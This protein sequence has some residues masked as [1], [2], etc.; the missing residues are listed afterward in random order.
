MGQICGA[1]LSHPPHYDA[2]TALWRY[3]FPIDRMIHALKYGERL[4]IAAWFGRKLAEELANQKPD[5]LL[6]M[7]LHPQRLSD[8]G[9]NQAVEITRT[10]S[11]HLQL[12]WAGDV[13]QRTRDTAPQ[14]DL[15]IEERARNVKD[16]F[17]CMGNLSGKTVVVVDDVMTTGATLNETAAAIKKAGAARVENWV[18]ARA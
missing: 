15:P 6:P 11:K 9:F 8:R 5:L 14:T 7:P 16:A 3:E 18:V 10:I 13:L 4:A 1:C 12:P 17:V 2:T